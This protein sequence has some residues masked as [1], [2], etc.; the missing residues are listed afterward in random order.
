MLLPGSKEEETPPGESCETC[1]NTAAVCSEGPRPPSTGEGAK[2]ETD[3][4]PE[5]P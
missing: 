1:R 3:D 5:A 4:D 2:D